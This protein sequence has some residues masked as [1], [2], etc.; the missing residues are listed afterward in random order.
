[1]RPEEKTYSEDGAQPHGGT[2]TVAVAERVGQPAYNQPRQETGRDHETEY[3]AARVVEIVLPGV[4]A[5]KPVEQA[6]V[7]W[8]T[9]EHQSDFVGSSKARRG[10]YS[11]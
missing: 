2:A 5:L 11:H 10:A 8:C 6:A 7:I 1:M 4:D 3:V 9:R